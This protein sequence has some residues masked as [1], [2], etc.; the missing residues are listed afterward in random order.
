MLA[1]KS[2]TLLVIVTDCAAAAL[3]LLAVNVP[4]FTGVV[5]FAPVTVITPTS[6]FMLPVQ[7]TFAV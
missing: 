4:L 7:D 6:A 5:W 3:L 2:P 1:V